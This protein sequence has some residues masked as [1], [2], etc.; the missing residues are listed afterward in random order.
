[1]RMQL[2]NERIIL[3]P[4]KGVRKRLYMTAVVAGLCVCVRERERESVCVCVCV[5]AHTLNEQSQH[6]LA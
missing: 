6:H 2:P 5:C 4:G 3:V 1:M